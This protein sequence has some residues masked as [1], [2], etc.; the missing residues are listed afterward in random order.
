[1]SQI[2][3]LKGLKLDTS[4]LT[5]GDGINMLYNMCMADSLTES[6]YSEDGIIYKKERSILEKSENSAP[7]STVIV[8]KVLEK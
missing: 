2:K 1:M 5:R 3:L 8:L 7:L 6:E 4:Y